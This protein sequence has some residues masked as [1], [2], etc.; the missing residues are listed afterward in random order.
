VKKQ[1]KDLELYELDFLVAKAE[2]IKTY[3]SNQAI[4]KVLLIDDAVWSFY[5]PTTN[6]SQSWPIIERGISI[7]YYNGD[8][9]QAEIDGD[10]FAFG[11]T[12]LEAAM[13]C[14]IASKFGDEVEI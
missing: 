6:Q 11:K 10:T 4:N 7:N 1:I 12:S 3:K 13:R 9:W 14:Y 8:Y 5:S 2:G